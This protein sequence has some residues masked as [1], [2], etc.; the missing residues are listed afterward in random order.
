MRLQR[1][2]L[3]RYGLFTDHS[4]ELPVRDIDFHV[5]FGPNE[6]GKSTALSA[7][8][9]LLFGVPNHSPYNFLHDYS[10][11]RVG[12]VL[13]NGEEL[14][15]VIRR[16]G[17]KN[18]LLSS[19]GLPFPEGEAKLQSFLSG[20][21]SSFFKRMFSLDRIRLEKGGRDI[22]EAKDEIGHML[23]SVGAGITG[24][25][26]RL[27][28][29]SNKADGLWAPR[30]GKDRKYYQ[31]YDKLKDS[32]GI[33]RQNRVTA[34]KWQELK[35]TFDLAQ[36]DYT[37]AKTEFEEAS[38]E[39]TKLGRI[40]RCYHL[41][42]RKAELDDKIAA[43]ET[44][45]FLPENAREILDEYDRKES[46]VSTRINTLSELL[47]KANEE[48]QGLT[49]DEK[50]VFHVGD[51]NQ[52]NE[53]RI[54][55]RRER[56]DL[57]KRQAELDIEKAELC[58]L[59]TELNWQEQEIDEIIERIP[60]QTKLR[61]LRSLLS[62]RG[63]LTSDVD[64]KTEILQEAEDEHSEL[65]ETL[66]SIGDV[67]DVSKLEAIV[68]TIRENS[69]VT[70]RAT[71]ADRQATEAQ[72]LI[73]RL[74]T[75]LYLNVTNEKDISKM[76]IPLRTTVQA[77]RDKVLDW[78]RRTHETD[79]Q[80]A[81]ARK[82]FERIQKDFQDFE[83][84][85]RIITTEEIQEA[86]FKRDSLWG[87]IKQKYIENTPIS[88]ERVPSHHEVID[89]LETAFEP[90]MHTADELADR[91]FDKVEAVVRLAALTRNL[92]EQE[93]SLGL[94]SNKKEVLTEEG[95]ELDVRWETL[96]G[97][98]PIEPLGPDAMLEWLGTRDELLEIIDRRDKAIKDLKI[99]RKEEDEAKEK[100]LTELSLIGINCATLENDTLAV[101]L[102]RA[103]SV[104]REY[105]QRAKE[106]DQASRDLREAG[107]NVN[108]R[109][110]ELAR[111]KS[112]WSEWQKEW[113]TA[114]N[115]LELPADLSPDA[116]SVQIEIIDQMREKSGKINDLRYRR[117]GKINRDIDE[118]ESAVMKIV[119]E[120]A[121]D[122]KDIA[123][124]NAVI[125]MEERLRKAK[126]I[127]D[128]RT[129]KENDI[130]EIKSNILTLKKDRQDTRD[131][132]NYL[133]DMVG[134]DTIDELRNAIKN[135]DT[136]RALNRDQMQ[137]LQTL[138][139]QGDGLSIAEL[140]AECAEIDIDH[141]VA[142]EESTGTE[143]QTLSDGLVAASETRLQA[144]EAFEAIGGDNVAARAEAIRQE[145]FAEI[146]RVA[147]SYVR[148]RTSAILLQWAIDRYRREK[149]APLLQR[150]SELFAKMTR[151]S[152]RDL[153]VDYDKSDHPYLTGVR[154]DGESV[155][156]SGM[157]SGTT[158]QLYLAL[159]VASMEDYVDR[160][161]AL[162][163][164]ADDLFINFDDERA[165]SGFRVLGELS[166]KTQVLFFTHHSHLL[167][168]ARNTLGDSI[169]IIDLSR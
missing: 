160:A 154:P 161:I 9:D 125:E 38:A 113:S 84:E 48:L 108:R 61:V 120:L 158:D 2:D 147:E 96:W 111:A 33:L 44:V 46:E 20:A 21:D 59:A 155:T 131:S 140:E 5:L 149:Q 87:L 34:S 94:L 119:A 18:T 110:R 69:D 24:L 107:T 75:S 148:V 81:I 85:E 99:H 165:G 60:V 151:G 89:R 95:E 68:K 67:I 15:E 51:I 118:F 41:V 90:A 31:A 97:K 136:L 23:F 166:R 74:L 86:R 50:L 28:D 7:I 138:E 45:V 124:D 14:L 39:R 159:R 11:M 56:E 163:F 10:N 71:I 150:A 143:L 135:S 91:R 169:S 3:F 153:R 141:I 1:L 42:R 72:E 83:R 88:E 162:P 137:T 66:N 152:F 65:Q 43:L 52:L 121:P 157:S 130:E 144:R 64:N 57:P 134:A 19:D 76:Q 62:Q 167:E 12:A 129:N 82:E 49:Y 126:H 58:A 22:L 123:A 16:K 73:D 92:K 36:Q 115:E 80:L 117:I 105:E 102:E 63:E 27:G 13:E 145:A 55:I 103:D 101:I 40:R 146:Q 100:L 26:D 54:E 4:F 112:I 142:Q 32:E 114:L 8:E 133:K 106:R 128:L 79:Q 109:H 37:K 127:Y 168:I 53:H 29:F 116:V 104:R 164:V 98:V 139:Q 132:V 30:R 93:N 17:L 156:V 6:A 70:I 122:L 78:E 77:H 25:R 35:R 47:S